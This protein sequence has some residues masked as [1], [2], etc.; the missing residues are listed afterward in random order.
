MLKLR[1]PMFR[2]N[3][4]DAIN[5]LSSYDRS[6]VVAV[7]EYLYAG[8]PLKENMRGVLRFLEIPFP[9]GDTHEPFRKA[10][11]D[12]L[13]RKDGSDFVIECMGQR[14][15]V[16][17]FVLAIRC[18]FFSSMFQ[19]ELEECQFGVLKDV[20]APRVELMSEFLQFIYTGDADF[21]SYEDL[22]PFLRMCRDYGVHPG[23]SGELEE[24]VASK[25]F[26]AYQ[27]RATEVKQSASAAGF[28]K[29]VDLIE[30]S[31]VAG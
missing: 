14:F 16:H 31:E 7:L 2:K 23:Y 25:L 15:H 12:L 18:E 11:Q 29:L 13:T 4:D 20:Y 28:R 10:M 5:R 3:R 21:K 6:E 19:A 8:S 1:W 27:A 24:F 30:S 17:K 22:I 26:S 9:E